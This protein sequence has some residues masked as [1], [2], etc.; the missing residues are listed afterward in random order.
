MS[1]SNK[2]DSS[3]RERFKKSKIKKLDKGCREIGQKRYNKRT[4]SSNDDE[5]AYLDDEDTFEKFSKKRK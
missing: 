1:K 3:P 5:Y 4:T 2:N